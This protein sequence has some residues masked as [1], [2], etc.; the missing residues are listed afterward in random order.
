MTSSHKPGIIPLRPMAMGDLL[1]GA[2]K[3]TRR[4]PGPV[5]GLTLLVLGIGVVPAVL[6]SGV[7]LAG[8]WYS[9][10]DLGAVL[11][12]S[13]FSAGLL[14]LGVLFATLV[15]TGM[16][17]QPV[18]EATLGRR[19][20]LGQIWASVRPR[21]WRL[22][23]LQ[24]IVILLV[25]IPAALVVLVLVL[26]ANGPG[27]L[28]F[29]AAVLGLIAL[30]VW[31]SLVIA[32]TVLAG[33]ALVLERKTIRGSLRRAWALSRG[34][35]WRV[36]GT[37]VLVTALAGIVF[38]VIE[39]PLVLILSLVPLLLDLSGTTGQ[40]ATSLAI[41]LATLV[42]AAV[43]V[44]VLAGAICLVYLDQRM[45]KEGFDLVLLRAASSRPGA[46]R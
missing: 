35:F 22:V 32:R 46:V 6:L 16:L 2:V 40:A 13:E 8:N 24:A 21:L 42:S 19:L 36:G 11:S 43:V 14:V 10:L 27:L 17:A 3:H 9:A 23:G 33:P 18:A 5:L 12:T 29:I 30:V 25:A 45:R 37:T 41:N 15:V 4:N 31:T 20:E 39:L 44:P 7:A 38:L 34:S 28:I 1:D 26:L